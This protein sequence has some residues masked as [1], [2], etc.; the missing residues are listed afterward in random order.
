M[1]QAMKDRASIIEESSIEHASA[2]GTTSGTSLELTDYSTYDRSAIA[3]LSCAAIENMSR[4]ELIRAIRECR[5]L[6]L[7]P[8][9]N[10]RLEFFERSTLE[11]LIYILRRTFQGQERTAVFVCPD[12]DNVDVSSCESANQEACCR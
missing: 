8:E 9:A 3:R 5:A 12:D 4:S 2:K 1:T 6:E 11:Q 7:R 10:R